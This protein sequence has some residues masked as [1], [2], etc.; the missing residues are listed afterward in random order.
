MASRRATRGQRSPH[1]SRIE[2]KLNTAGQSNTGESESGSEGVVRKMRAVPDVT[3]YFLD[4]SRPLRN[5]ERRLLRDGYFHVE[6]EGL[7]FNWKAQDSS[8]I[9]YFSAFSGL[10]QDFL[11]LE[12]ESAVSYR[13]EV[14]EADQ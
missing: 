1:A 5:Y 12:S 7:N 6:V 8:N 3:S 13:K 10:Y 2:A 14:L 4:G 11:N 9:T